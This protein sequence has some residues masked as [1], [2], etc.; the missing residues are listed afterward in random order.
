MPYHVF[1]ELLF[2]TKHTNKQG[3]SCSCRHEGSWG[4]HANSCRTVTVE[5]TS[6][7]S[8]LVL[9]EAAAVCSFITGVTA[10]RMCAVITSCKEHRIKIHGAVSACPWPPVLQLMHLPCKWM[11]ALHT[12]TVFCGINREERDWRMKRN[13]WGNLMRK[14]KRWGQPETGC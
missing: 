9:A 7:W 13:E 10:H 6:C 8:N 11:T 3:W 4:L 5:D 2:L 14:K 12:K 1:H